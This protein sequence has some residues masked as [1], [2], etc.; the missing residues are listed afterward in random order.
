MRFIIDT[1]IFIFLAIENDLLDTNVASIIDDY[2]NTLYISTISIQEAI[3][4]HHIGKVKGK[5]KTAKDII[6]SISDLEISIISV[7][8]E[9]LLTFAELSLHKGHNDPN[10]HIIISQAICEKIPVI[11]SDRQFEHYKNQGLEFIYNKKKR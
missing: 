9:H 6:K 4:L 10:D 1:N 11:S 3:H 5:W 7:N 8:K 2:E